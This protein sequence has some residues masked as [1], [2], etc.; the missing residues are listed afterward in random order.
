MAKFIEYPTVY[1]AIFQ[2]TGKDLQKYEDEWDRRY[3]GRH[4]QYEEFVEPY[5]YPAYM[6]FNAPATN[7]ILSFFKIITD[8]NNLEKIVKPHREDSV[9][10]VSCGIEVNEVFNGDCLGCW[11]LSA[12]DEIDQP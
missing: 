12:L 7:Q 8:L 11:S 5:T 4:D 6:L 1:H 9:T 2:M 10:C 3:P